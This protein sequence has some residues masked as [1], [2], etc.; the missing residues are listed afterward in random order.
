V[1]GDYDVPAN[2]L[3]RLADRLFV[4]RAVQRDV[5]YAHANLKALCE[6]AGAATPAVD[7]SRRPATG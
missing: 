7:L 2:A 3:G 6:L 1:D 4:E 5:E